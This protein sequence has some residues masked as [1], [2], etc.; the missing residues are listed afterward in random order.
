MV[1]GVVVEVDVEG[2]EV[3]VNGRSVGRSPLTEEVLVAPGPVRVEVLLD[4]RS[5]GQAS[6]TE[7]ARGSTTRV[8]LEVKEKK[9]EVLGAGVA[10]GPTADTGASA[11]AGADPGVTKSLVPVWIGFGATA[12]GL[13]VGIAFTAVSNGASG[14]V[15]EIG[16]ELDR[17]GARC[18]STAY[19]ARCDDLQGALT[20]LDTFGNGAIVA[21]GLAGAALVGTGVYWLWP[22]KEKKEEGSAGAPRGILVAPVV[23]GGIGGVGGLTLR[24]QF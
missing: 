23:G 6:L 19:G 7:V 14:D 24:G 5:L 11:R 3:R 20:R 4:G 21:F 1:G 17:A 10:K 22:V 18:P 16:A 9:A 2:A 12:V 8:T 15:D 13:G